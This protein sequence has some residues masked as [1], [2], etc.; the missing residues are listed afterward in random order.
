MDEGEIYMPSYTENTR[1]QNLH[2]VFFMQLRQNKG[3][4]H[5]VDTGFLTVRI[6]L[7]GVGAP[8]FLQHAIWQKLLQHTTSYLFLPPEQHPLLNQLLL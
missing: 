8:L 7:S 2:N 3:R 6:L 4:T 5:S 1:K